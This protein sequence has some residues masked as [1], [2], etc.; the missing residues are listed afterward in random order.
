M[1]FRH[2]RRNVGIGGIFHGASGNNE[3]VKEMEQ[4]AIP[5]TLKDEVRQSIEVNKAE[6]KLPAALPAVN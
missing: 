3:Q 5:A 1:L 2:Y 4:V 6:D